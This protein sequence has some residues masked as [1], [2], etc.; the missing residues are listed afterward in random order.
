MS[1]H[2]ASW[3]AWWAEISL[4]ILAALALSIFV[5]STLVAWNRDP[6]RI[7]LLLLVLTE[8]INVVL[9]LLARRAGQRDW[10]P[11][12]VALTLAATFY[13]LALST[14][15]GVSILSQEA[16]SVVQCL[17]LV[18]QIYAKLCLGRC[19]GLLPA[20]RGLVTAGAYRWVR[21]PIYLGY[22]VAHL[23]FLAANFSLRNLLVFAVLYL[24]QALRLLRE[25]RVLSQRSAYREYCGAVPWRVVPGLF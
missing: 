14:E 5:A 15:P 12:S 4:R 25:E 3:S 22:L 24:I 13:F 19:F 18:W 2:E 17:G 6:S 9:V 8:S 20:H 7:T 23:G 21:H 10:A 11:A 1:G 16:A